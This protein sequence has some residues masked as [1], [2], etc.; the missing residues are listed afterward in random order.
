VPEKKVAED[1]REY[2]DVMEGLKCMIYGKPK[3]IPND[4]L[5]LYIA[6]AKTVLG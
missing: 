4:K 1:L 2:L 3:E 5:G 6:Y